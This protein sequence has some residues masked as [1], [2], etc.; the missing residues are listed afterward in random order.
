MQGRSIKWAQSHV[1]HISKPV[2][3]QQKPEHKGSPPPWEEEGW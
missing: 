2:T 1:L 3:Y